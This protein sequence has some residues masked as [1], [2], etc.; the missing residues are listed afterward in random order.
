M[1]QI[2]SNLCYTKETVNSSNLCNTKETV[3]KVVTAAHLNPLLVLV[4]AGVDEATH[5]AGHIL[6]H[7][8]TDL[9]VNLGNS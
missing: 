8:L 1:L 2:S 6:D 9:A 3:N 7:H 5:H 4:L